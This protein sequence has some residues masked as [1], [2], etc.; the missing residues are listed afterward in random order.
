MNDIKKKRKPMVFIISGLDPSGKAGF[1]LDSV[2]V[3]RLGGDAAGMTSAI[4][5]QD[6]EKGYD[7]Y[8]IA[9]ELARAVISQILA[10]INPDA[11]KIGMMPVLDSAEYIVSELVKLKC[12]VVW[13]PV[14][15]TSDGLP[16]VEPN[17]IH[18]I[19]EVLAPVVSVLTPNIPEASVLFHTDDEHLDEKFLRKMAKRYGFDGI[20]LKGGHSKNPIVEDILVTSET[21]FEYR[22]ERLNFNVRGTGCA[23]S[24][25]LAT[26]LAKGLFLDDAFVEAEKF[27]DEF[28]IEGGV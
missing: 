8:S 14:L 15:Q 23:L 13:D 4:T 27:M 19:F 2:V 17:D 21:T 6:L 16:L 26:E 24:S 1:I 28:L 11:V 10:Q 25:A 18:R 20:L 9:E 7:F 12:P 22:R 3:D 5:V